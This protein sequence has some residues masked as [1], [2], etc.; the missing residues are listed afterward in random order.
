M[1]TT[2]IL[3]VAED[4]CDGWSGITS[5]PNKAGTDGPLATIEEARDRIRAIRKAGKL[6][7]PVEVLIHAGRY[8]F[9]ETLRFEEQDL[10]N[11]QTPV[12]YRAAGDGEAIL[13]G[14]IRLDQY[15]MQ[16]NGIARFSLTEAGYAGLRFRQLFCNGIRQPM[17]RYPSYDPEQPYTGGYLYVDGPDVDL[18]EDGHG[19]KDGFICRDPRLKG[20]SRIDEIELFVFP[21]TNYCND[22]VRLKSYDPE[23]GEVTLAEPTAYEIYPGDRFYFRNVREELD[24]AGEWYLDKQAEALYLNPPAPLEE[25]AV[26][27]PLVEN[28][29]EVS[30]RPKP[31]EDFNI[32]KIDWTDSGGEIRLAQHPERT[33]GGFIAFEG[34]TVEGCNG[35]GIVFRNVRG[36]RVRQCEIRGTGNVG[37]LLLGGIDCSVA[38]CE[39]RDTGNHGVYASG[40]VRSPFMGRHACR[41][42]IRNNYVHHTGVF[43]KNSA[44]IAMNGV[45]IVA[46]HNEI[47]DGPRWGILSRGSDNRIEY[48]RIHHVNLETSDTAAIYLVDRDFS[49]NG[50]RILY[51]RIHDVL[52]Y[53]EEKWRSHGLTYGIYLDDYTSGVEVRGNLTY[54]TLG[55]GAYIHAGQDNIIENNMFLETNAELAHFRRWEAEREYRAMGT[56][57]L[58][59]RRNVFRNNILASRQATAK[60]YLFSNCATEDHLPDIDGNTFEHNFVWLY[61]REISVEVERRDGQRDSLSLPSWQALGWDAG[62]RAADPLIA[63]LDA[64]N[65][66]LAEESPALAAGFVPLPLERM[67]RQP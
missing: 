20:W 54:R 7:S 47:H 52:G 50:T 53:S 19:R 48:N 31:A 34:L 17:A 27:V 26:T 49:M 61:G 22:I 32:E 8:S 46:A 13:A 5:A 67:G 3:H 66:R 25:V 1:T 18:N 60:M 30:G 55:G 58:G 51:N 2:L 56:H 14:G 38:D 45:G 29:I 11:E 39:I 37:V 62:T 42:E 16:D 35:A 4:G 65:F 9:T 28:L 33:T 21:R 64:E 24:S 43:T 10:G 63:D 12:T 44:G 23:T 41:H 40:G 15:K 57:G 59:L 6:H 36:C